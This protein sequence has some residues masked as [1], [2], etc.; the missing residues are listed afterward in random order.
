MTDVILASVRG[1]NV[2]G[3]TAIFS[4]SSSDSNPS[5]TLKKEKILMTIKFAYD[6]SNKV[7]ENICGITL[8]TFKGRTIIY[9]IKRYFLF[10][11]KHCFHVLGLQKFIY[12]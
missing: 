9:Q 11:G 7:Q 5:I 2:L 6:N 10:L 1:L 12:I 8:P 3:F 4:K